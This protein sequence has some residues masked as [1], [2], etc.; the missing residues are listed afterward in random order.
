MNKKMRDLAGKINAKKE[1]VRTHNNKGE[2]EEARA[3]IKEIKE[4]RAAYEIEEELYNSEKDEVEERNREEE[5]G[6]LSIEKRAFYKF[7]RG[8]VLTPEER[9]MVTNGT[10]G[11]NYIVPEDINTE[12]REMR[13]EYKSAKD[14]I[15]YYSSTTLTGSFNFEDDSTIAELMNFS[16]GSDVPD[17]D[18]PKINLTSYNIKMY[19]AI[20]GLSN[21]LLQNETGGLVEY[22]GRWF[23]KKAI[24]TENKK[25][26]EILK[27]NKTAKALADWKALK[28]SLNKDVDPGLLDIQITTNQD[29]FDYLDTIVDGEGRPLMQ[30]DVTDKSKYFFKGNP[31]HVFSNKLLTSTGTKAPIFYGDTKEG[32][33]FVERQGLE[34]AMSEHAGFGKNQTQIRVIELFDVIQKD[35]DAYM[36]GQLDTTVP[37]P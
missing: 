33:M 15:D 23:N 5:K 1:E 16:D 31:I 12:I 11:E 20:L 18:D 37:T 26:F 17:S 30:P 8:E 32:A 28:T 25:I 3:I 10:N 4:L 24:M 36:Y 35:K 7:L 21:V 13:R 9:A 27:S 2:I 29:G 6:N 22:I 14:I 19:G 34:F